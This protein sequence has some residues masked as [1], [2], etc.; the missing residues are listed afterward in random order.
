M[1]QID[2]K[3]PGVF[4]T[5]LGVMSHVKSINSPQNNCKCLSFLATSTSTQHIINLSSRYHACLVFKIYE[6]YQQEI[7]ELKWTLVIATL[8]IG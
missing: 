7:N 4:Q 1:T 6:F 5:L 8:K 3:P 2:K